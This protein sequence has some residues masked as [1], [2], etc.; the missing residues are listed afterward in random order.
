MGPRGSPTC[1]AQKGGKAYKIQNQKAKRAR[2]SARLERRRTQPPGPPRLLTRRSWVR[3]PPGPPSLSR[4][5]RRWC[6][7]KRRPS[8]P[9][10][11]GEATLQPVS[12]LAGETAHELRP[13]PQKYP[14][15][16][17][18]RDTH[19]LNREETSTQPTRP[20]GAPLLIASIPLVLYWLTDCCPAGGRLLL[21]AARGG[22]VIS[23][24]AELPGGVVHTRR[25]EETENRGWLSV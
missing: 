18:L 6:G 5:R 17:R 15:K 20:G 24:D 1:C 14:H 11:G 13:P 3:I 4:R 21:S 19:C 10:T 2:S 8:H 7:L 16:H 22:E 9:R 12:P 25:R 23:A